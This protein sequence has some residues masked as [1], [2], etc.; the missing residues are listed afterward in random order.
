MQEA[1][2]IE[3]IDGSFVPRPRPDVV[4]IEAGSEKVLI[5]SRPYA[6]NRTAALVW[7]CFDGDVTLDE[8]IADL[9]D[10]SGADEERVRSDVVELTRHLASLGMLEGLTGEIAP[11]PAQSATPRA[12]RR[13]RAGGLRPARS[14]RQRD[15]LRVPS[16]AAGPPRQLEPHVR[17]LH[18]DCRRA[19]H[20]ATA[21]RRAGCLTRLPGAGQRG[22]EPR[23]V[24][25]AR[26]PHARVGRGE[27]R[28]LRRLRNPGRLLGG[29]RGQGR[30]PLRLR[31]PRGSATGSPG[32][33]CGRRRGPANWG[34]L[35]SGDAVRVRRRRVGR[36]GEQAWRLDGH[37]GLPVR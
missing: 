1:T 2:T 31:R 19:R 26:H 9:T 15:E 30:G 8:L 18:P 16:V 25:E 12:R 27:R 23:R 6:L 33:R 10:V 32:R 13:R 5:R 3:E 36:R 37:R 11:Q 21:A 4:V 24:R 34:P 29:R 17:V 22:R 20:A 35:P 14:R 28:A 7:E